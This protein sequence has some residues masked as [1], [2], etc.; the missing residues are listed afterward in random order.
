MLQACTTTETTI[1]VGASGTAMRLLTALLA[2]TTEREVVLVS[3]TQRMT[4]RP[5]AQLLELLNQLGAKVSQP[6]SQEPVKGLY[7]LV[8]I[9]PSQWQ[10]S[11]RSTLLLPSNIGSSQ[12]VT[13]LLLIAPYLPYGLTIR[14]ENESLP[15]SSYIALT[16]ALMQRC[17]I[18]LEQRADSITVA[19]GSYDPAVIGELLTQPIGDWSSAQYPLQWVLMAPR[20]CRIK[21][22]NLHFHSLQPDARAL[23]LLQIPS[24]L[25]EST[26]GTVCFDSEPLQAHLRSLSWKES[27]SLSDNP[28][29]A[30][31]LIALL[32]F[33][34]KEAQL[35]DLEHL[36]LKESDRIALILHNAEQLGYALSY[37]HTS[38][39]LLSGEEPRVTTS[40]A[41]ISTAADHRMVMAWAPFA[42]Y[43]PLQ[44]EMPQSVDKSYPTFWQDLRQLCEAI[45]TPLHI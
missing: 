40:P 15:S 5:I 20:H 19:S 8:R 1:S 17:G 39:F 27:F 21:L 29:F 38:G 7:P 18:K 25:L 31:T 6:A 14:W 11:R 9:N 2:L 42:W 22:T 33:Y 36:R 12:I 35:R 10:H 23:E 41:Q 28:D 16:T 26:S 43:R 30:P 45:E 32:L 24:A 13:A 44:I 34:Q 37:S 3:P 4:E